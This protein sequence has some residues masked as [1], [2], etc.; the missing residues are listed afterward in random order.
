MYSTKFL[1][2]I[3]QA[4]IIMALAGSNGGSWSTSYGP[5]TMG[6][7]TSGENCPAGAK[8]DVGTGGSSSSFSLQPEVQAKSS[9]VRMNSLHGLSSGDGA[10]I[11]TGE[12]FFSSYCLV[13]LMSY[14]T[15]FVEKL[16]IVLELF[17][18]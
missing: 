3:F 12:P 7:P 2:S 14:L 8:N 10:T 6:R 9:L 11:P 13:L 1:L 15:L 5:K 18:R 4:D 16:N 17:A